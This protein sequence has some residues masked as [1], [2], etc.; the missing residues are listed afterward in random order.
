M[1]TRDSTPNPATP[2]AHDF[3]RE[4]VTAD[5]RAGKWGGKVTTRFPPEPNG[6][7]HIGHAKSICLNFG[8]ASE[9]GGAC[10][11]RMDDTNPTTEDPE[12]VAAIQKDVRWLGFDWKDNLFYAS[13]YYEQ[14][15]A[16][17][18]KLITLGRAYV[19]D[20]D[21][22][23]MHTYRGTIAEAG[24]DSPFRDRS[25][26]ENLELFRRMRKGELKEGACTL[27]AKIDM[28]S[29]NMKLRDPPIYRIKHAHH[30]RTKDAWCIYPLYDFAHCLSDSLEGITHSICTLEFESARELYD[31]VIA[32]T[33][34]PWVPKQTEF[35][36][37]NLTYTVMSKRKL[38]QLVE[39]KHVSGWDDPRMPTIAG[40]RRRGYTAE[41]IREF[42]MKIGVAKNIS[43]VDIALLEHTLREDLNPRS[44]RVLTVLKPLK[45]VLENYDA[46]QVEEL[47]A[48][49]WPHDIP[50][51]GSRKLPFS[52]ELYIDRDDFMEA[53][54][55]DFKRLAP[56]R[57]VRLR[58]AYIVT[59]ER[60][61]KDASGEIVELRCSYDP[62]TRGGVA[63]PGKKVDGT[64]QWVSAAHAL[65]AEV[66]LYDR[67]FTSENPGEDGRDFKEELNPA[68]CTI[69]RARIEPS[70]AQAKAGERFQFERIGFFFVDDDSKPGAL[71]FN[72]TVALKDSWAKATARRSQLPDEPTER[73][74]K[75]PRRPQ[76][77][78]HVHL[79]PTTEMPPR[80]QSFMDE[81]GLGAE[82]ARTIDAEPVLLR[83]FGEAMVDGAK[84]KA[85]ASVLVND[86][87]GELRALGI[88]APPFKG[89]AIA[90]L[91][92]L[93]QSGSI[94]TKQGK[95][96]LGEMLVTGK[97]P[98]V[99]VEEQ[100]LVQIQDAS[101]IEAIV[102]RVLG[103]NAEVVA[104]F[105][106]GN[107]NVVGALVGMTI[108]ASGGKA[109]PKLV[110]ELVRKKLG[111]A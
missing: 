3:I 35:A 69:V 13:D 90:E 23:T 43:T 46:A 25:V 11:L 62:T 47:D 50:K 82:E 63:A 33:E 103:Q 89:A 110:G 98:S 15:Y 111:A 106:A 100:G 109:N 30:Y 56:G 75:T 68:S 105:K 12:Y 99:I 70:L 48:A 18:E 57:A 38:L 52:R 104:R 66:R 4:K 16:F 72:R 45:V 31:W 91:V 74:S 65:E 94:S 81:H 42:C 28:A 32:A 78:P 34:V 27:R 84:P 36:R 107:T 39:E 29:P 97:S 96:V 20:L 41:A 101:A 108:K 5:V 102:D 1:S 6:Y 53:P 71:V 26:D 10:H 24:K 40:L 86:L 17:A 58:H 76:V 7:L 85:V 67:L 37:L 64:I 73:V 49:Y 59:C 61:I 92:G 14:L 22:E 60:V 83:L 44:P 8:I 55:K 19:C 87:R 88:D 2:A 93:V 54:P 80:A 51:E 79:A 95:D 21:E 77:A 9:F